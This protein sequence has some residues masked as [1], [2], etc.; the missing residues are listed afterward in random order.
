M[1]D[2]ISPSEQEKLDQFQMI[3][4][5]KDE[6]YDKVVALLRNNWWNLEV[7]L[8]KYFDGD[9]DREAAR[10]PPPTEAT[11]TPFPAQTN[12]LG[13]Q[14]TNGFNSHSESTLNQSDFWSQLDTNSEN[15]TLGSY[16]ML[17]QLPI[18]RPLSNNWK[19]QPGL[20][21]SSTTGSLLWSQFSSNPILFIL[22]IVPRTVTLIFT[23]IGYLLSFIFPSSPD[24]LPEGPSLEKFDFKSHFESTIAD[25][26]DIQFFE[27]DFNEAFQQ[28]KNETRFLLIILIGENESSNQFLK[29]ILNNATVSNL[30]REEHVVVYAGNVNEPQ[31]LELARNLKTIVVP[32]VYLIG[33]VASGPNAIASMSILSR[34]PVKSINAFTTKL[35]REIE[36][37][38][39]EF[40][41]RKI[42]QDELNFSR[43]I[44][45]LQDKAYEES[46]I[47]DKLKQEKREAEKQ[48][49]LQKEQEEKFKKENKTKFFASLLGKYDDDDD[50][51]ELPKGEFTNIRF[52]LPTGE[53]IMKKFSK[54]HTLHDIYSY[55][56]LQI[57]LKSLSNEELEKLESS[58]KDFDEGYK[59]EF[60]FE[61]ISPFPRFV[62]PVK[63][64]EFVKDVNQL[65]PNGNILIEYLVDEDEEEE[66]EEEK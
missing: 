31:S 16:G 57:H 61:L 45:E 63:T 19:L 18:V 2:H 59:H 25:K 8:S 30:I 41:T 39:P 49:Q 64:E 11:Q 48:E 60:E 14:S 44:K 15:T 13:Y 20:N 23:V 6:E 28:A 37:Y 56:A 55:I 46:L 27:G 42:E 66:E 34:I 50:L 32:S 40:I 58:S 1:S 51:K 3:T 17:P 52:K 33:N 43:Q 36:K 54:K 10:T 5:F 26:S 47:A 4:A 53:H 29:K 35:R 24:Y 7:A 38:K 12:D 21:N 65:W 62:V 9:L 22:L